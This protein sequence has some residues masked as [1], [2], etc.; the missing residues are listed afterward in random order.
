MLVRYEG[1]LD[2]APGWETFVAFGSDRPLFGLNLG[3]FISC[4]RWL[5][6]RPDGRSVRLKCSSTSSLPLNPHRVAA[7]L[8]Y[9]TTYQVPPLDVGQ[10]VQA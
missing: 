5:S 7:R 10:D 1:T 6:R 3:T 2:D 9:E 4:G 8:E